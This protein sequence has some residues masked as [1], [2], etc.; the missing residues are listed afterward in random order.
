[1]RQRDEKTIRQRNRRLA[2]LGAMF[3]L[4]MSGPFAQAA[5]EP[6][7]A[8]AQEKGCIACHGLDGVA[9][10]PSYPN[11]AGQWERYLRLQLRAYR[12]GERQN[13]IMAGFAAELT[14]DEIRELARFYGDG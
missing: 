8:L 12:S 14:D 4:A 6:G 5:E 10:A 2:R 13:Q 1:M 9:V 11:L 3:M 7:A